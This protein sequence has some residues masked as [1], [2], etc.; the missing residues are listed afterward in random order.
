M[1]ILGLIPKHVRPLASQSEFESRRLWDPVTV[2]MMAKAWGEA[3][4]AKQQIEQA[5][6]DRAA[7]RKEKN[8]TFVPTYFEEDV[9]L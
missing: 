1:D 5:Q 6:R 8:E 9:S 4:A 7:A 2:K 3:T